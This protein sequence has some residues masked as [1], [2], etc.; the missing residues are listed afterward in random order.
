MINYGAQCGG[1]PRNGL[2]HSNFCL[3][4]DSNRD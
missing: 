1:I 4:R 2:S 3:T